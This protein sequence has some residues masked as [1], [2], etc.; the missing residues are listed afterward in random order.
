MVVVTQFHADE[1]TDK[2]NLKVACRN[3]FE[4]VP[5]VDLITVAAHESNNTSTSMLNTAIKLNLAEFDLRSCHLV[6]ILSDFFK[7]QN[8]TT[9]FT[10][11]HNSD[12]ITLFP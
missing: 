9:L 3:C 7:I 8:N 5:K 12:T 4:K 1:R 11:A 6:M 2:T 10:R